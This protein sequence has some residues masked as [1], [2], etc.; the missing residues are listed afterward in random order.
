MFVRLNTAIAIA[1]LMNSSS[2][3]AQGQQPTDPQIAHIVYTAGKIDIAAAKQALERSKNKDVKAFAT[4]MVRDHEAVNKQALALLKKLKVTPKDNETSRAL[5][6]DAAAKSKARSKLKGADFD[7]AYTNDEVAYHR[8][9]NNSLQTTL[10]P[11][12]SNAELKNL[13]QRGLMIF[14]GHEQHAEQVAAEL[15]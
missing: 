10:I 5:A 12:A 1:A 14:K 8:T 2:A 15:K 7:Q 11:S 3:F 6:R 4:D 9:V 13:L